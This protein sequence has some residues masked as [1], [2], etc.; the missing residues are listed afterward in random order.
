MFKRYRKRMAEVE[1]E[2]VTEAG[3]V[4]VEGGVF[5]PTQVGGYVVRSEGQTHYYPSH[6]FHGNFA[7]AEEVEGEHFATPAEMKKR[8]KTTAADSHLTKSLAGE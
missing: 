1:A 6:L 2:E 5:T 3:S 4:Q 7:P 8:P